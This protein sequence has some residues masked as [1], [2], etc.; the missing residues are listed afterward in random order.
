MNIPTPPSRG[1]LPECIFLE[2]V[3]SYKENRL[4]NLIVS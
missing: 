4:Q 1:M 3:S 2:L